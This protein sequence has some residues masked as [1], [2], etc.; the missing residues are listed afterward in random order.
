MS[1][2]INEVYIPITVSAVLNEYQLDSLRNATKTVPPLRVK[3]HAIVARI[4]SEFNGDALKKE[5]IDEIIFPYNVFR[6]DMETNDRIKKEGWCVMAIGGGEE[7]P[8]FSYTIGV[9]NKIGCEVMCSGLDPDTMGHI[10]NTAVEQLLFNPELEKF[11]EPVARFT[12][13]TDLDVR[14]KRVPL[15]PIVEERAY[16]IKRFMPGYEEGTMVIL[17]FPDKNGLFPEDESYDPEFK[18]ILE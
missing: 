16:R 17:V 14:I 2:K 4:N 9:F 15:G 10:L 3:Y 5:L 11:S 6:L 13:G 18:Q 1:T 7:Q 12:D 8:P